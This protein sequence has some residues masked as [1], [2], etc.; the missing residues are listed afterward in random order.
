MRLSSS[1]QRFFSSYVWTQKWYFLL[2][3]IFLLATNYLTVTIPQEIGLAIDHL[4]NPSPYVV[5]IIWMGLLVIV[6]RTLS[7]VL[8]F[9][10]SRD[11]E[12]LLRQDLFSHLLLLQ[13]NFY[14]MHK[15]GDIVSRASNDITWVRAMIGFGGMMLVN[16][17]LAFCLTGWKM[18]QLSPDLTLMVAVPLFLGFLLVQHA[19]RRLYPL[20]KKNQEELAGISDQILESLQGIATV[21]GF[22]AEGAFKEKFSAQNDSWFDTILRLSVLQSILTPLLGLSAGGAVFCLIWFGGPMAVS[23]DL[24][25]GDLA[26]FIALIAILLPYMRSMGWLLS[27]W[28]RGGAALDRIFE[29]FDAEADRPELEL[30]EGPVQRISELGPSIEIKDLHFAYHSAEDAPVFK[31]ISC[32]IPGGSTTGIFGK[33]GSGKSTFLSLLSRQYNSEQGMIFIDGIDICTL[34]LFEWRKELSYVPQQPFLF[35]DSIENN[36]TMTDTEND[37][38]VSEVIALASLQQ[39]IDALPQGLKTVVGERG[40]MLSG[41]QRQRVALARGLYRLGGLILLD[42]VLSAVDHENES[43][44]VQTLKDLTR[45]EQKSSCI[46]VSNRI[47]AFRHADRVLVFEEGKII[48]QGTHSELI[49]RAGIY[50]DAW[51][52]QKDQETSS[53]DNLQVEGHNHG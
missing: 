13:P 6:V 46:I 42:D 35:S 32:S 34:D 37:E 9:N 16:I 27:V 33:T 38:R 4:D 15:R 3:V 1:V 18:M 43:R 52:V 47:S 10:P 22:S 8:F 36:I 29:L 2:G 20:M 25:V 12:F 39:D 5:K 23:G 24:S 53:A 30:K 21:Q 19:I 40:I 48:D 28:Q 26:A 41:G 44:L 51:E 14:L 31:G 17:T 11:I 45:S 49:G 7:R 50:R